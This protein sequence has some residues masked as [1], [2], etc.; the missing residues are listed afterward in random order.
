MPRH[1][2]EDLLELM[3]RLRDPQTGCP[4]DLEQDHASLLA[5]TLEEVYELADAVERGDFAQMRDELGDYLFQAVFYARIAEEQGRFDFGDVTDAIVGK[6]LRRHPHVFPEGRLASRR[7]DGAAPDTGEIRA[8]WERIKAE[9]RRG[10]ELGGIL[11]DVPL[12]LPALQRAEKLQR[13]A[14][15]EGFD[16]SDWKGV[17][18]KLE[19]ELAEVRDAAAGG[20]QSA[21]EEEIGDLL[22]TCVNLAR[23]LGVN[24]ENA[25][26]RANRKFEE[27]FRGVE[28][29]VR[30]RDLA[31]GDCDAA[32]LDGIWEEVKGRMR[33]R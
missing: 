30:R 8:N 23:H 32:L 25:L 21:R 15:S 2:I 5:H 1:G 9:D 13:R 16:W 17:V 33:G 22:F 19:E 10:R 24:A 7:G 3:R 14:A 27:R 11:D 26:R 29:E 6:L 28:E 12:A 31:M 4:W 18:E 20:G